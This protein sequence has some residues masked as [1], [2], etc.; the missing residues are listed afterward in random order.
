MVLVDVTPESA[1]EIYD[2]NIIECFTRLFYKGGY[3][4]GDGGF[5]ILNFPNIFL[6]QYN[7][8]TVSGVF[9]RGKQK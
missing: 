5:G 6:D 1:G 9:T 4:G 8:I 3:T 2:I 7:C